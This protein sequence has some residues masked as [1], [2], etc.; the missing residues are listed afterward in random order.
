MGIKRKIVAFFAMLGV[1][2]TG[3]G[4]F[5]ATTAQAECL[6]CVY[7]RNSDPYVYVEVCPP[8]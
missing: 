5:L 4:L 1:V 7:V 6:P 2:L 3:H 8:V